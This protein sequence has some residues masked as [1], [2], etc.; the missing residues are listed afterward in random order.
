MFRV[1]HA[2]LD[3]EVN[4]GRSDTPQRH[5]WRF[6]LGLIRIRR[7][8][9][10]TNYR[11]AAAFFTALATAEALRRRLVL[12]GVAGASPIISATK[13]LVTNSL[14]PW[15]SKSIAVRSRSAAVT[16]PSP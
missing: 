8:S 9:S 5:F 7:G 16:M 14:G 10:A 6:F 1:E 13:M 11:A 3:V 12:G 4:C 15:S 2:P